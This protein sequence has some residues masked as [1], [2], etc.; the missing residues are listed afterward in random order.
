MILQPQ[1]CTLE[2]PVILWVPQTTDLCVRDCT[3]TF[4]QLLCAKPRPSISCSSLFRS[5][6]SWKSCTDYSHIPS[7]VTEHICCRW[8]LTGDFLKALKVTWSFEVC[9]AGYANISDFQLISRWYDFH[10]LQKMSNCWWHPRCPH[11]LCDKAPRT[12][13]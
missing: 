7:V 12:T 8:L 11:H 10:V 4:F 2:D 1:L 9:A 6:G 5:Y 3:T 13:I